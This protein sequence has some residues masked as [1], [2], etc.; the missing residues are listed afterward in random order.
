M[1]V[2]V[3][4]ILFADLLPIIFRAPLHVKYLLHFFN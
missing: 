4:A 2:A 3:Q 1:N